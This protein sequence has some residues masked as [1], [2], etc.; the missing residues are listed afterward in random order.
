MAL[1]A[2][3]TTLVSCTDGGSVMRR[4][5][6][7]GGEE[8]SVRNDAARF[9]AARFDAARFDAARLDAAHVDA[10]RAVVDSVRDAPSDGH[11]I[12]TGDASVDGASRGRTDGDGGPGRVVWDWNGVIGTG[13]SL[14]VGTGDRDEPEDLVAVSISQP[15]GNLKLFD[16]T[17]F[18]PDAGTNPYPLDGS[19]VYSLVP[20]KEPL[21]PHGFGDYE[22]PHDIYGETPQSG[23]ANEWTFL[24][25]GRKGP[26]LVSLHTAVGW[27]AHA[28]SSIDATGTGKAYPASLTEA[29]IFQRFATLAK[30]SFG[31]QAVILTHGESDGD[32]PDY[33]SGL[34]EL[35]TDYDRDLRAITGQSQSVLLLLSQQGTFPIVGRPLSTLAQWRAGID[36]PGAIVC[37]GP[38]YQYAFGGLV[39]L[40][41][42]GYR[43]LGE[44]Y[45]EVLDAIDRGVDWR[46]L[47]PTSARLEGKAITVTFHV[48]TPPLAW[49][50]TIRSPHATMD[51]EWANGRGFEVAR[52]VD[53]GAANMT[54]EAA[55]IAGDSVVLTLTDAPPPG[56]LFVRYALTSDAPIPG[57][58]DASDLSLRATGRRGQ[59]RDSNDVIGYDAVWID[60]NAVAGSDVLTGLAPNAFTG[61]TAREI[62]THTSLPE[63]TIVLRRP[64]RDT[65]VL[66]SPWGGPSGVA[67]VMLH[68]SLQNYA[69]HFE[70]PVTR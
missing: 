62:V 35:A 69:V 32:N 45:A 18:G 36:H 44:K 39:H 9:D 19:G 58:S 64:D 48:P 24:S 65:I 29:R 2:G 57:T 42:A 25:L 12:G 60:V 37:V 3:T 6:D 66:S 31:Y 30:K 59:L 49:D 26:A 52:T 20:L 5:L 21:R 54:I 17:P 55:D 10:A 51:P 56:D 40:D 53:G 4:P 34:A 67:R 22:Y 23:M 41:G 46:P 61:R 11:R 1:F 15:Y 28:L 13:Q 70:L 47:E 7:A 38:K 27:V 14:S 16:A 68:N 43:R 63:N 8:T 33:E 50:T